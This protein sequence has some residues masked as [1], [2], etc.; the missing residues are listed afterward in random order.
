MIPILFFTGWWLVLTLVTSLLTFATPHCLC[1]PSISTVAGLALHGKGWLVV[2]LFYYV[3]IGEFLLLPLGCSKCKTSHTPIIP[4]STP[5]PQPWEL[6]RATNSTNQKQR[7]GEKQILI[8]ERARRVNWRVHR[9]NWK[10][11]GGNTFR[12]PVKM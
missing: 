10:A 3:I 9:G 8:G 2:Q 11:A 1:A 12:Y 5:P 7:Q 4:S 6:E